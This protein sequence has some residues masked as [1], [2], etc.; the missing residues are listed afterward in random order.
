MLKR[1]PASLAISGVVLSSMSDPPKAQAPEGILPAAPGTECLYLGWSWAR[2][3]GQPL[4]EG[5]SQI[6]DHRGLRDT[7]I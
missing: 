1:L 7:C 4:E 3:E 6:Q 5:R 2:D